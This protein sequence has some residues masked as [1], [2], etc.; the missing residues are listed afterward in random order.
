MALPEEPI[1]REEHYLSAIAGEITELP[2]SPLTRREHYLAKIAGQDVITPTPITREDMYLD[3]IAEHGSGGVE[4]EPLSVTENGTYTAEEGK[5]YTPVT[6]DVP[7]P[8]TGTLNITENGTYDVTDKASAEVNVPSIGYAPKLLENGV[9]FIDFDGR[10]I[11][12][13]PPNVV[14]NKTELPANPTR[15]GYISQGWNG[16]L[17]EIKDAIAEYPNAQIIVGQN[18]AWNPANN[19]CRFHIS[20]TPITGLS[21]TFKMVGNK[22]W[23]DGTTDSN[24]SH[25]YS[26]YGDYVIECDG[27]KLASNIFGQNYT[28]PNYTL[29]EVEIGSILSSYTGQQSGDVF[30]YCKSLKS[31]K[32]QNGVLTFYQY[33]FSDCPALTDINFPTSLQNLGNHLLEKD[34]SLHYLTTPKAWYNI[35]VSGCSSLVLFSPGGAGGFAQTT[36]GFADC[37]SLKNVVRLLS[38]GQGQTQILRGCTNIEKVIISSGRAYLAGNDFNGCSNVMTYDFTHSTG[39]AYLTNTNSFTNINPL[40]KIIVPDDLYDDWI[41]ATNWATYANYIYKASEVSE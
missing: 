30:R 40:C 9:N 18:Y 10:I 29:T 16:T 26:D 19:L 41:V 3:F 22:D 37:N 4:A 34:T 7:N 1:T 36:G 8:S 13:W 27:N 33:W 20:L 2:E 5:A 12:S 25:T 31:V 21:V 39:V 28:N 17:Q 6:V 23:G 24:T 35:L 11:E 15:A 14:Q 38:P 32:V